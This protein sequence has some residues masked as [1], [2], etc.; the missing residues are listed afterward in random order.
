MSSQHSVIHSEKTKEYRDLTQQEHN[1][2]LDFCILK[3]IPLI[4]SDIC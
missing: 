2:L 3:A 1:Q 4:M